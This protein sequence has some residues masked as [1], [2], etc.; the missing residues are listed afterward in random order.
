MCSNSES[1]SILADFNI[2]LSSGQVLLAWTIKSG[3]TCNGMQIFRSQDSIE[4]E[5]IE[6]IQGVCG[7]LSSPVSYTFT[8]SEP[9]LNA[10]NYYKISFG[11]TQESN[12][13]S[14]DVYNI[15]NNSYLLKPNPV[16][17]ISDLYFNNDNQNELVLKVYGDFGDVIY[18]DTT[19]NTKFILDRSFFSS[20]MYYF[21]CENLNTRNIINGKALFLNP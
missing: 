4:Y 6:D 8:D 9:E 1:Q 17:G 7:D 13:L 21:S 10:T 16:T 11:G 5:L 2:D 20:G 3:S 15:L 19:N 12:V 18:T 14:I